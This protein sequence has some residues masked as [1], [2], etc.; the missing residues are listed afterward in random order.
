MKKLFVILAFLACTAFECVGQNSTKVYS[1]R[2]S[3]DDSVLMQRI[4]G[5]SSGTISGDGVF[6]YYEDNGQEIKHGKLVFSFDYGK[7]KILGEYSNGNKTGQWIV[8]ISDISYELNFLQDKIAGPIRIEYSGN[9]LSGNMKD[10]HWVGE[11][12]ITEVINGTSVQHCLNFSS[13]GIADHIWKV[14]RTD[15]SCLKYEFANGVLLSLIEYS[16]NTDNPDVI[17]TLPDKLK[18]LLRSKDVS[19]VFSDSEGIQ[20]QLEETSNYSISGYN[21][22]CPCESA[23]FNRMLS[24]GSKG[25]KKLVNLTHLQEVEVARK[26]ALRKQQE[27]QEKRAR[28]QQEAQEKRA[29][30]EELRKQRELEEYMDEIEYSDPIPFQFV[31][32]K[33]SFMGGSVNKFSEWINQ[34]IV[35]PEA[36]K[37]NGAEGSVTI[38]FVINADG[39]VSNVS[40]IRGGIDPSLVQEAVRVVSASP[41]WTP[42]ENNDLPVRTAIT[43]P[44]VF[45]L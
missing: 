4:F 18:D 26:E 8:T 28:E 22:G 6:G 20:Y 33:P 45:S 40:V 34:N 15:G 3:I 43:L 41:K 19:P 5:H 31:E 35:Y 13:N 38:E 17:Y 9:T 29:R 27:E 10:N 25:F 2:F 42:G 39:S 16:A 44:V 36:A 21:I 11:V 1:G 23:I 12:N 30:E 37:E 32:V 7:S 24:L 14:S